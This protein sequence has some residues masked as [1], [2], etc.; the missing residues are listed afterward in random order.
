M[1]QLS[2]GSDDLVYLAVEVLG[3][4]GS[5][6]FTASGSSMRPTLKDGD[7]LCAA[8]IEPGS[9]EPG[10]VLL[11]RTDYDRA[12]VHRVSRLNE[13]EDSI[14]SLQISSDARPGVEYE[15]TCDRGLGK[16]VSAYRGS[17]EISLGYSRGR[18]LR[19]ILNYAKWLTV[20]VSRRTVNRCNSELTSFKSIRRAYRFVLRPLVKYRMIPQDGT[21][22]ESGDR[23][24][25]ELFQAL[26]G[27]KVIGEVQ[28][29]RFTPGSVFSSYQWL[30][31]MRVKSVF[32]G[33]GIGRKLTRA[34]IGH[35]SMREDLDL[36]LI[37]SPDNIRAV[38]LYRSIGFEIMEFSG[39][40]DDIRK[41]IEAS[42]LIMILRFSDPIK[43]VH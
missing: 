28:L 13:A 27:K 22:L 19:N 40:S 24:T 2:L 18:K 39:C 15:I 20:S 16:I 37:V 36:C 1:Q 26:I 6:T 11:Y 9:I 25:W 5:L 31:S 35:A 23:C 8:A 43:P 29:V 38:T 14:P 4:G 32:R 42:N 21:S 30:F 7:T 17:R 12:A 10:D 34:V 33:C 41:H 3:R